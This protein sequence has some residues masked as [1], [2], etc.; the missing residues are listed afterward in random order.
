MHNIFNPRGTE[1]EICTILVLL[2]SRWHQPLSKYWIIYKVIVEHSGTINFEPKSN[3]QYIFRHL[4][5][6]DRILFNKVLISSEK[7]FER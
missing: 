7:L 5:A 4:Y 1:V 2:K 6:T 3:C